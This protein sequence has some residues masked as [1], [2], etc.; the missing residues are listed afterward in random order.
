VAP[1]LFP[2][3]TVLCNFASVG[4]LDLL[5]LVLDGQGRWTEAVAHEAE[6][7]EDWHR[8][9]KLIRQA[10][11]LGDPI[12]IVDDAALRQVEYIRQN[13]L[14]GRGLK[15]TKHLG[16]AQT[17]YLI[18]REDAFRGAHW[19]SDD[20]SSIDYAH[21]QHIAVRETVHIVGEAVA[22]GK[23]QLRDGFALM[24]QMVA[25]G[26]TLRMPTDAA[27]LLTVD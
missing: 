5:E 12:S 21:S 2:D 8:D 20:R 4:R 7:S 3:T 14:G 15:P 17:F 27:D 26:R 13:P 23:I 6:N 25:A 24:Q 19:I 10:G 18:L 22:L 11:W 1:L 16:E 9:L